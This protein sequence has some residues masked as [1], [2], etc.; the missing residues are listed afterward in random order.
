MRNK[1]YWER[2]K[3]QELLDLLEDS[4]KVMQRLE[5]SYDGAI[6]GINSS[7]E[8][9]YTKFAKD[10]AVPVE[11]AREIIKGKEYR[12]WRYK[13]DQYL[14]Q[15][16]KGDEALALELNVL[17]MR[18]RIERL[19]T[20][21][22]EIMA[23]TALLAQAQEAEMTEFLLDSLSNTYY[24]TMYDEYRYG[25]PKVFELMHKHHVRVPRSH[26]RELLTAPWS[27]ANYSS[28][29]WRREYDI[30]HKAYTAVAQN[31]MQGKS[32]QRTVEEATRILGHDYQYNLKR[33][34][35][36]ETT[37]IK[38]QGDLLVYEQ[39]GVTHY[40]FLATL[41]NRTSKVCRDMDGEIFAIKDAMPG[42]NYPPM[43]AHC[44]SIT[45][46][47]SEESSKGARAARDADTGKTYNIPANLKY[48]EWHK[49]QVKR[50][51]DRK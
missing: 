34:I 9:L 17:C 6:D 36:T 26:L 21:K 35:H 47:A 45:I 16:A 28:R 31:I 50:Q 15:I 43:H 12:D 19:E 5:T 2:R 24:Q 42:T 38:A 23:Q 20:I 46:K 48:K 25:N 13:M 30:A 41:D 49:K 11:K 37:Y 10:N 14:A 22:A 1:K 32:I 7:I 18:P 8:R 51:K 29:I 4:D 44:R 40:Q 27:G 39:L 33:L 3:G